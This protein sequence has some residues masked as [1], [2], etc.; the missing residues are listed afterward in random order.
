MIKLPSLHRL[1]R[2]APSMPGIT[3]LPAEIRDT[4]KKAELS[5]VRLAKQRI[6][7]TVGSRGIASLQVAIRTLCDWL[8]EEGAQPF[9]IPAMGSHGGATDE[10]QLQ[11]LEDY[12][13]TEGSMGVPVH[14]S[15]KTVSI[16][17]TP[18]GCE[19]FMNQLAHEADGIFVFNRIKPH[20]NFSGGIESGWLKIMTVGMGKKDGAT[21]VH[22]GAKLHGYESVI[23]NMGQVVLDSGRIVGALGVVENEDQQVAAVRAALPD[24]L[25]AVEEEAQKLSKKLHSRLPFR[26]IRLLIVDE[27]GKDISGSGMDCK[28]IG[29]GLPF[30]PALM[31]EIKLI[32]VRDLTSASEGN[33]I[34]VGLADLMHEQLY[35]KLDL[36]KVYV[37]AKTAL[38]PSAG[39]L[40]MYFSSDSQAIEFA[41]GAMGCISVE[42]E[43]IV[44]IKNTLMLREMLVSP[45]ILPELDPRA[46]Y[47]ETSSPL[48]PH[49]SDEGNLNASW[50]GSRSTS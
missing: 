8:K 15:M 6:A 42:R 34:G 47:Q 37:N 41:L 48:L 27:L 33:G 32:Y 30:D 23:R 50:N 19:V 3:D 45:E 12:G 40:P 13:I 10:G 39:R 9:I 46:G 26:K 11:V 18:E 5:Q 28:V 22:Q 36:R 14:S 1:S 35:Q 38:E 7:V 44:W 25:V 21:V 24:R 29:R 31:P 4:L 17:S 16:G 20:T 43:A 2:A 49:F